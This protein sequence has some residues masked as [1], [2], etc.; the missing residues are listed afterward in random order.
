MNGDRVIAFGVDSGRVQEFQQGIAVLGPQSL[1]DV[2]VKDVAV[3]GNFVWKGEVT[4]ILRGT[5]NIAPRISGASRS[6]HRCVSV[7]R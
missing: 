3:A 2:E 7:S 5:P 4:R 1:N 6:I